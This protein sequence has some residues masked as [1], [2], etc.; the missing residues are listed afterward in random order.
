MNIIGKKYSIS[1]TNEDNR[2]SIVKLDK[3]YEFK[4]PKFID[5]TNYLEINNKEYY[6]I[7]NISEYIDPWFLIDHSNEINFKNFDPEINVLTPTTNSKIN[8][9][10]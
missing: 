9:L 5:F 8:N 10:K 1:K 6:F 2:K 4:A 7:L 3:K